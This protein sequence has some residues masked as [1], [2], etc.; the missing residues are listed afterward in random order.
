MLSNHANLISDNLEIYRIIGGG[1]DEYFDVW[2]WL[3]VCL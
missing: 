1:G 3:E 2:K